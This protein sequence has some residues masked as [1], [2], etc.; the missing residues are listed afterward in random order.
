MSRATAVISR[1][2]W[3]IPCNRDLHETF[4]DLVGASVE[5]AGTGRVVHGLDRV[6]RWGVAAGC[7][8]TR[9]AGTATHI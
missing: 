7:S 3:H 1:Q 4:V 6:Q 8:F 5:T 9:R 2:V